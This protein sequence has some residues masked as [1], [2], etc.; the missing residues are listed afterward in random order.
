MA[1]SKKVALWVKDSGM[2]LLAGIYVDGPALAAD[3]RSQV[4]LD[5]PKATANLDCEL[6]GICVGNELREGGDEPGKKRFMAR[7]SFGL[8]RIIEVY[9]EWAA[10]RQLDV[11]FAY[12]MERA[13]SLTP[14]EPLGSISGLSS[15]SA[16]SSPSICTR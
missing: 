5:E 11:G 2:S 1:Y 4:R 3:W 10:K 16:S 8:A 9:R 12:A 15:T 14:T 13:S 6:A 7:L